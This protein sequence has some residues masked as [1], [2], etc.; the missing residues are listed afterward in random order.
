MTDQVVKANWIQYATLI[1]AVILI[2][3][4]FTWMVPQEPEKVKVPSAADIASIVIAGVGSMPSAEDIAKGVIV[5]TPEQPKDLDN[6]KVKDMW[7]NLYS[8]EIEALE[9][10]AYD[11][12]V[13]EIDEDDIQD[14]L[15]SEL[16]IEID[17][18]K[19]ANI[20]DD[21]TEITIINLG[22]DDEDDEEV[23]VYIEIKV[24]Y[25]LEEGVDDNIK[26]TIK[27]NARYFIDDDEDPD[28]E[29]VYSL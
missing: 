20:D 12:I 6:Q 21:E 25:D 4:S 11:Y 9:E 13:D 14:F 18:I 2:V 17:E 26:K 16:L 15:E 19:Y 7:E 1:L 27:L 29:L 3:G 5:P 8:E 28:A 24:K 23:E 22:L 10:E